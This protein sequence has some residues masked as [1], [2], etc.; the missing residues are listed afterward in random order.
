MVRPAH[1]TKPGATYF[2]TT[3]TWERRALFRKPEFATIVEEKLFEYRDKGFY[4][5]CGYVIMPDHLHVILT[6]GDST[7]L[8]KAVQLIKGGSSH[9]IGKRS[10][11][12]LPVWQPGFAE[13]QIRD[14]ADF[15]EHVRYI[16]GNP[17]KARL[18]IRP[19]E[20]AFSS[21][22]SKDRLDPWPVVL[23]AEA[24]SC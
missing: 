5:L 17:V 12:P 6:P 14:D 1:R 15:Q 19:D 20:Y 9:A 11:S 18:V 23:G 8:E 3:N 16:E 2:I 7:S 24:P 21:M 4:R 22:R 10:P 13:H